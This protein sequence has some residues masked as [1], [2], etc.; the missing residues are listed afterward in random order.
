M[1]KINKIYNMDRLDFMKNKKQFHFLHGGKET[2]QYFCPKCCRA[3]TIHSKI[4]AVH[5]IFMR[6]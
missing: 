5:K 6:K 1:L 3:H 4:G 2:P